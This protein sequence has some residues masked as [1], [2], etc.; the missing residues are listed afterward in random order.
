MFHTF[1]LLMIINHKET[2]TCSKMSNS[3]VNVIVRTTSKDMPRP[4][5]NFP[6]SVGVFITKLQVGI[7]L[8]LD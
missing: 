3:T 7:N 5:W 8:V 1:S 6:L 4:A 2:L